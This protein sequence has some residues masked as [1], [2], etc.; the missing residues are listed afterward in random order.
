M[1]SP[2][3]NDCMNNTPKL[4]KSV[5]GSSSE[6]SA[7]KVT[8]AMKQEDTLARKPFFT[9][10]TKA[11]DFSSTILKTAACCSMKLS[12]TL[13]HTLAIFKLTSF[14][15]SASGNSGTPVVAFADK[16]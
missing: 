9:T 6:A 13:A 8:A 14:H 1:L 5:A 4:A 3:S 12:E 2:K 11:V 16:S 7:S 10:S 15:L